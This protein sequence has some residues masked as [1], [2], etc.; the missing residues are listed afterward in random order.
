MLEKEVTLKKVIMAILLV[1]V[2]CVFAACSESEKQDEERNT[3]V[4][5]SVT[6]WHGFTQGARLDALDQIIARFEQAYPNVTVNA[7]AFTWT[8]FK[9]R[10]RSGAETG[11][12]PDIST[13]CNIYEVEELV[14]AG[15]LQPVNSVIDG[16]GKQ[17][18]ADNV[19]TELSHG[20]DIYG[21]PY[22]SHAF[23]LWYRS[24]LLQDANLA[25]P[26]TWEE[27]AAAAKALTDPEKGVYGYAAALSPRDHLATID[28]HVYMRSKGE[29]LLT[30]DLKANL[31]SD[32]ALEGIAYWADIYRSCSSPD[33]YDDT[34]EERSQHFYDGV[35]AF[36][37]NSGFHITG[38]KNN[39]PDLLESISCV[40]FPFKQTGA[41]AGSGIVT[42]I[43]LVMYASTQNQEA[44]EAFLTFL[45]EDDNYMTFID[46]VPVGMIPAIKDIA[47]TEMYQSNDVRKQF[48]REET[49]I[50]NAVLSGNALGF[51]HGANLQAGILA[52]SG[53]IEEMF[54][55]IVLDDVP[56]ETAAQQAE[57]LLNARFAQALDAQ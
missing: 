46:S 49:V 55:A 41:S 34:V 38:I 28:L 25:V 1:A 26:E 32:V 56:V 52:S 50:E 12:L 57:G 39:R 54:R 13:A 17:R 3:E 43:P 6:F 36:D 48:M 21:L 24:D 22:Y 37:V 30:E 23:V 35:T 5:G 10:W 27:F 19:L 53:V 8:D 20:Q 45:Y 42:Q 31:T 47:N 29:S 14:D 11:D 15:I 44:A 7:E 40:E 2:L 18:F 16:I 33:F 4:Q 9:E 51:E